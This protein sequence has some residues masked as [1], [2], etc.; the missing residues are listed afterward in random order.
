MCRICP[1]AVCRSAL[2]CLYALVRYQ[3][4]LQHWSRGV[5]SSSP[6]L[7]PVPPKSVWSA[8]KACAVLV[9]LC[10]ETP[11]S[12]STSWL[13]DIASSHCLMRQLKQNGLW[14]IEQILSYK[15]LFLNAVTTTSCLFSPAMN[16]SCMLRSPKHAA[17]EMT[18]CH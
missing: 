7:V 3:E 13:P 11:L 4:T 9:L 14:L 12:D 6:V 16:E 1:P 5:S 17:A 18:H 8:A 2:T 15:K 10:S